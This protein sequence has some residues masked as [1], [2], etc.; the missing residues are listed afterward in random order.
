MSATYREMMRQATELITRAEMPVRFE[1]CVEDVER[2]CLGEQRQLSQM[3]DQ[4]NW[5]VPRPQITLNARRNQSDNLQLHWGLAVDE[6]SIKSI[7]E[8]EFTHDF[9]SRIT[10]GR[11]A[12]GP[13]RPEVELFW[14]RARTLYSSTPEATE[15]V[16]LL[17]RALVMRYD[18]IITTLRSAFEFGDVPRLVIVAKPQSGLTELAFQD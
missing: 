17:F 8:L 16:L 4:R 2:N 9:A 7:D 18:E 6:Y 12:R 15:G 5:R 3:L 11:E 13:H 1:D 14:V 10:Y